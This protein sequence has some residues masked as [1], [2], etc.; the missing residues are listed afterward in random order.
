MPA[1]AAP[2]T[3]VFIA[4][5]AWAG[6][7]RSSAD[8]WLELANAGTSPVDLAGWELWSAQGGKSER[9]ITISAGT[10][11]AGGRF[12]LANNGPDHQFSGG[13][14][15]LAVQPDLITSSL[16]LGNS[17]LRLELRMPDGQVVDRAGDGGPPPAGSRDG[18]ASMAR[19]DPALSG[20][21][22]AAWASATSR[23]GLDPDTPDLGTPEPSGL[24]PSDAPVIAEET[25]TAPPGHFPQ[26]SL[27]D[28]LAQPST[29]Q[30]W[31]LSLTIAVPQGQYDDRRLIVRDGDRFAEL[32]VPNGATF[33]Y[34]QG[35][36]VRIIGRRSSAVVPRVLWEEGQSVALEGHGEARALARQH[37]ADLQ[38]AEYVELSGTFLRHG[39]SL[40]LALASG[41][42]KI[43][44]RREVSTAGFV[45]LEA[46]VRG[47]VVATD[48]P[49]VRILVA[50]DVVVSMASSASGTESP[51]DHSGVAVADEAALAGGSEASG[52]VPIEILPEK[53]GRS[54][55]ATT[56][57]ASK[58]KVSG[59]RGQ[60]TLPM[61][62]TSAWVGGLTL[63][64]ALVML[65]DLLWQRIVQR[66]HRSIS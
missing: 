47:V 56:A 50:D 40:F 9:M 11:P 22:S 31:S 34:G 18:P 36:R 21:E 39:R 10:L 14:S 33:P 58:G 43:T 65:G 23:L 57:H 26:T 15:V 16:S 1:T 4:E 53:L 24:P 63:L 17:A 7:S 35:S 27:A 52:T 29:S 61:G 25:A 30:R 3:P 55:D 45:G 32:Q 38:L 2:L 41:E 44:S 6:S 62:T 8:E 46:T 66:R 19:V 20:D 28:L 54:S 13:P 49:Q 42:V 5:I 64:G 12:L 51:S 48:P 59:A 60:E 37:A